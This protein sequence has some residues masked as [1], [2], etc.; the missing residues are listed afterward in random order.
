VTSNLEN[1]Y[2]VYVNTDGDLRY[3]SNAS[4][5]RVADG[6]VS[7]GS[8]EY[9]ARVYGSTAMS[10]GSDFGLTTS[11]RAVQTSATFA[12]NDRVGLI[13]KIS[14][15][16]NTPAGSYSQTITYTVTTNF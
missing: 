1:G 7:I 3:G 14:I 10:T 15:D 4:I 9:G 16:A 12:N 8:E 13:Y 2:T 6:S 5:A 11:T